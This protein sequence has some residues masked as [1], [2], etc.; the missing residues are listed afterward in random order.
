MTS[1][2][3]KSEDKKEIEDEEREKM[4]NAENARESQAPGAGS[5][6]AAGDAAA[7]DAVGDGVGV[8]VERKDGALPSAPRQGEVEK[9]KKALEESEKDAGKKKIPI[10]GIRIPGFLRSRSRE[11]NNKDGESEQEEENKDLL[12]DA[13]HNAQNA[14]DKDS[15][16]DGQTPPTK[17]LPALKLIPNPFK[18]GKDVEIGQAGLASMET[19]DDKS[20][21]DT[22]E[23]GMESVKLDVDEKDGEKAQEALGKNEW[24]ERIRFVIK[25]RLIIGLVA[26]FVI[27]VIAIFWIAFSGSRASPAPTRPKNLIEAVTNCGF[28]EGVREQGAYAFRGIPY[29]APP[30]G[31]NRWRPARPVQSLD[32]CWNGTLQAHNATPACW[33]LQPDGGW[34]GDE[35]CLTLDVFTPH[36]DYGKPL[37]VVVMVGA[38]TLLGGSPGALVP[39]AKLAR[40]R[41]I[42]FVRPNFRLG[43][44]GFLAHDAL[45]K[46]TYPYTSG[47][48][49]LSD[50][51]A[52]LT[53]V[54]L[55]IVNFGGDPKAVTVLGHRAGATLVSALLP[56]RAAQKEPLFQ[57]VWLTSGAATFPGKP[58]M[59]SSSANRRFVNNVAA[60]SEVQEDDERLAACLRALD[61]PALLAALPDAWRPQPAELPLPG[62]APPHEWLVLDGVLLQ[63]H[64]FEDFHNTTLPFQIVIG[65]TQHVAATAE[66]RKKYEEWASSGE[67]GARAQVLQ[68]LTQLV[69]RTV[70]EQAVALYNGTSW[71]AFAAMVSD[72][73]TVCPLLDMARRLERSS[74]VFYVATQGRGDP[75]VADAALDAEAITARFRPLSPQQRRYMT[76]MQSFFYPFVG[77]GTLKRDTAAGTA[78][79]VLIGQDANPSLK[80]PNCDLWLA[81]DVVPRYARTD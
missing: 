66:L 24:Q 19:L 68:W 52:A 3:E 44:L 46:T 45:T 70:A 31:E 47:N 75:E 41:E 40:D 61:A 5:P 13:A 51:L 71:P 56:S 53:W 80:Y 72:I 14:Q 73:R 8:G 25:Y 9:M 12:G 54:K 23:D 79:V 74:P 15:M 29:A 60:C 64:P 37:P 2:E 67:D 48:Y 65:T 49:G 42:V 59:D 62:Q 76:A 36:V 20:A 35:D 63:R 43:V 7:G 34:D 50:V 26:A 33:Q 30:V 39:V 22:A 81:A 78:S 58:L 10:G 57:R 11:K 6:G 28:V 18:K 77:M 27:L 16:H 69:N 4:L 17:R 1:T 32:D 21:A 38:E 55:N